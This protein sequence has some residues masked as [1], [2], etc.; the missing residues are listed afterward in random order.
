[1]LPLDTPTLRP[2]GVYD[3]ECEAQPQGEGPAEDL[4]GGSHRGHV[5]TCLSPAPAAGSPH[6]TASPV[7][8]LG[9]I[10][11]VLGGRSWVAGAGAWSCCPGWPV[12]KPL[13]PSPKDARGISSR[14]S[15]PSPCPHPRHPPYTRRVHRDFDCEHPL[16]ASYRPER[17]HS[18][19]FHFHDNP[20]NSFTG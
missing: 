19:L 14:R 18:I 17:I 11:G 2:E 3:F 12:P 20:E 16:R 4:A 10:T 15:P 7:H 9:G 13:T 5:S 1:M 8:S 6:S